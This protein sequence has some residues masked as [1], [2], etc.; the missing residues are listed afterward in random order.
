L[1]T[2]LSSLTQPPA[3]TD[4]RPIAQMLAHLRHALGGAGCVLASFQLALQR[5]VFA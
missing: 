3:S 2:A 1:R 5:G 4:A